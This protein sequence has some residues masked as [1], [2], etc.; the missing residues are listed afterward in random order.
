[1]SEPG[2]DGADALRWRGAMTP[3]EARALL[4]GLPP[5][6]RRLLA[7]AIGCYLVLEEVPS[8]AVRPDQLA[9]ARPLLAAGLLDQDEGDYEA[10][11]WGTLPRGLVAYGRTMR[12]VALVLALLA[13]QRQDAWDWYAVT[14]EEW[15]RL[16]RFPFSGP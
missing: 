2:E 11:G 12:A 7:Q 3:G 13:D 1:M 10:A 4:D 16:R 8:V 6:A 14:A 9:A 5:D 15:G